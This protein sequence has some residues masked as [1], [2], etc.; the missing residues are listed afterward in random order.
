MS[1]YYL[2]KSYN[3][4]TNKVA[5]IFSVLEVVQKS[6]IFVLGRNKYQPFE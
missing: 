6:V 5:E 4:I 2:C 1:K 3:S